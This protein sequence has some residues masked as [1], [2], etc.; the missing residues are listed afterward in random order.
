MPQPGTVWDILLFAYGVCG[1]VGYV[2]VMVVFDLKAQLQ[3]DA[4]QLLTR[5]SAIS[6]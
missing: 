5:P 2:S 4:R 1:N 3:S 6:L